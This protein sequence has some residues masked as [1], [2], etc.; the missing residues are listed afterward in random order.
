VNPKLLVQGEAAVVFFHKLLEPDLPGEVEIVDAGTGETEV[1]AYGV[2]ELGDDAVVGLVVDAGS[3]D[4]MEYRWVRQTN[5]SRLL[6]KAPPDQWKV[7]LVVPELEALLFQS[8]EVLH[9]LMGHE[10][11]AQQLERARTQPR[12]VLQQML[13]QPYRYRYDPELAHRLESVDLSS[14]RSLPLREEILSFYRSIPNALRK[15]LRMSPYDKLPVEEEP[16]LPP[17]LG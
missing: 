14:L 4:P 15:Y 8:Q 6:D 17:W 7:F 9:Q 5:E 12:Q 11:T 3:C 13:G 1:S 10:F 2:Q 16:L